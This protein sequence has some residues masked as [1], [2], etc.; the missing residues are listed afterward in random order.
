MGDLGELIQDNISADF[1]EIPLT[2]QDMNT[3]VVQVSTANQGL[4]PKNVFLNSLNSGPTQQS[5][6][7]FRQAHTHKARGYRERRST[8]PQSF[9]KTKRTIVDMSMGIRLRSRT[10]LKFDR[11]FERTYPNATLRE[12]SISRIPTFNR[13]QK[14]RRRRWKTPG[15][16]ESWYR[17]QL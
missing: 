10:N 17:S 16:L 3:T 1:W 9:P 13:L 14:K 5:V 4:A 12:F 11:K 8:E 2:D 6:D 7:K 15:R